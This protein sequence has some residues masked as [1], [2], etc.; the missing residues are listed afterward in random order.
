MNAAPEIQD[1]PGRDTLSDDATATAFVQFGASDDSHQVIL[2]TD[3]SSPLETTVTIRRTNATPFYNETV[4]LSTEA[5]AV[6]E[7]RQYSEFV[8]EISTAQHSDTK[9][10]DANL[11]DCNDSHQFIQ[12][13]EDGTIEEATESTM[14]GCL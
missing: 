13:V 2:L 11:I 6:Y 14:M 3:S 12:L 7:F 1:F 5:Y 8:I 4:T 10:V 9:D